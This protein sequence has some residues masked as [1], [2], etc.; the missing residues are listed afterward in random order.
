[1]RAYIEHMPTSR[2]VLFAVGALL[3]AHQLVAVV[4]PQVFHAV[5]PQAVRG[6]LHLL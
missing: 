4:L 3:A 2:W 1:M 5:V 6:L